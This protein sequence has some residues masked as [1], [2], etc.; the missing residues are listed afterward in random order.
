MI[1]WDTSALI[2]CYG[3]EIDHPRAV[4]LLTREKSHKGCALLRIET[5]SGLVRRSG[6]DSA[7][8]DSALALAEEH[9][10]TFDLVPIDGPLLEEGIRLA[11]KHSLRAADALHLAAVVRLIREIG[12]R[13][14]HFATADGEQADAAARER[15][16]V[17]RLAL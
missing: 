7:L 8:R 13:T 5:I 17:I 11:R 9:L 1:F 14:L 15:V 3:A 4:N 10:K 2:K 16:K 12:R 6:L